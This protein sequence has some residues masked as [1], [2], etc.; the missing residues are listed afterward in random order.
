MVVSQVSGG[1]NATYT[2]QTAL[3]DGSH[4]VTV[5]VSDNDGNAAT[6][7]AHTF[8]ISTVPPVLN[9]TSPADGLIT[10]TATQSVAGVTNATQGGS[11]TV[12]ITLNGT[13]QGEV[14][15]DGS[16]NFAKNVTLAEGAN[17][18]VITSTD[19][20]GQESTVTLGVTLD[21][22]APEFTAISITP[23]PADAGATLL[24]TATVT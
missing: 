21:T 13:D 24:I 11:V 6:A 3:A 1:Y 17:T 14:T 15:V 22:T 2:P 23:N 20:A 19:L 9:V 8:T 12:T 18:I 7:V 5:N 16:G 10:A 4:T